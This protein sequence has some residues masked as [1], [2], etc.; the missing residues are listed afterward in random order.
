MKMKHL[1]NGRKV[2]MSN[3]EKVNKKVRPSKLTHPQK[4]QI[5]NEIKSDHYYLREI[6]EK[7]NITYQTLRKVEKEIHDLIRYKIYGRTNV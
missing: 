1:K 5:Y 2:M 4:M 3:E 7:H 6:C